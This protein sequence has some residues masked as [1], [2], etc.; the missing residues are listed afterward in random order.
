MEPSVR[1][2]PLELR[3]SARFAHGA[4]LFEASWAGK[5]ADRIFTAAPQCTYVAR[6]ETQ[7]SASRD[8]G[9][10]GLRRLVTTRSPDGGDRNDEI[11][12]DGHLRN[13]HGEHDHSGVE[14]DVRRRR[15]ADCLDLLLA[16]V[17]IEEIDSDE[18]NRA[19]SHE[20]PTDPVQQE[21]RGRRHTAQHAGSQTLR[22]SLLPYA[23]LAWVSGGEEARRRSGSLASRSQSGSGGRV[24]RPDGSS[25]SPVTYEQWITEVVKVV[26][27]VGTGIMVIGGL[28]AF[29]AFLRDAATDARRA[30]SY[31]RL[32][33]NLGRCILLG[34]EVLIVADIVRTVVVDQTFESVTVLGIIVL[35]R[36]L[37]SFS[38]A[39]EIDGVWPWNRL[40]ETR[41]DQAP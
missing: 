20:Q 6:R 24:S 15:A 7:S 33:R 25:L 5:R 1:E 14:A 37:L 19:C 32:R 22:S 9:P 16:H 2:A 27:T 18:P 17:G 38:L 3:G 11:A 12:K 30:G 23:R 34:L 41:N 28:G 13:Q 10:S 39:V 31:Q 8:L 35:I 36:I 4:A 29:L 21:P 40:R 26:E